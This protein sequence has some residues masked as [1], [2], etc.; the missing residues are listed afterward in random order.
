MS[1]TRQVDFI[2]DVLYISNKLRPTPI[3]TLLHL[4]YNSVSSNN[5]SYD[6]NVLTVRYTIP[7]EACSTKLGNKFPLSAYLT[8]LDETTTWAI[9]AR[10]KKHRPGVSTSLSAVLG[11]AGMA[12]QGF[13]PGD[14]VDIHVS[15]TKIGRYLGFANAKVI[16][17]E[18]GEIVCIG[19]HTKFLPMGLL[20]ETLTGKLLPMVKMYASTI[21]KVHHD[22]DDKSNVS[23]EQKCLTIDDLLE[24]DNLS[25]DG[26]K[27]SFTMQ[28]YHGNLMGAMHGGCQAMLM[29]M[30]G[31]QAASN[32][33]H[34]NTPQLQSMNVT[35]MSG[36]S[37]SLDI[38]VDCIHVQKEVDAT[39]KVKLIM[40]AKTGQAV[41]EGFLTWRRMGDGLGFDIKS[42]L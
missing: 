38:E 5:L 40:D 27:A 37:K 33:L 25:D 18:T 24:L 35:Y 36:A 4:D 13:D 12:G 29:E 7:R 20:V 23:N 2:R 32:A 9:M 17:D 42:K 10:D 3:S 16:H 15:V 30:V 41:S 28:R 14:V 26:K 6:Q 19:S 1:R 11:P 22:D 34:T 8:V 21:Q 39:M 31:Y